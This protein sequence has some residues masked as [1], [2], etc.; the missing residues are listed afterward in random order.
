MDQVVTLYPSRNLLGLSLPTCTS[1]I[2]M[3]LQT[4]GDLFFLICYIPG[5]LY[6]QRFYILTTHELAQ[7]YVDFSNYMY[8]RKLTDLARYAHIFK[9]RLNKE[10]IQ[11]LEGVTSSWTGYIS[12]NL[13]L[14]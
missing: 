13:V 14:F 11:G 12:L 6:L 10:V 2:S 7:L 3:A 4:I 1:H 8:F 5:F 9:L